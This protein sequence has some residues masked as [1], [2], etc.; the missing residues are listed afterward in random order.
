MP[1]GKHQGKEIAEVESGY[2]KWLSERC[3]DELI[4]EEAEVEYWWREENGEHFW[5]D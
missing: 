4:A 3:E 2:L 1:W 5:G